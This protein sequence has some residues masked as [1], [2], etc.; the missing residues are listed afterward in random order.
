M[1]A[2]NGETGRLRLGI[3]PPA[4]VSPFA[5]VLR[6]FTRKFPLVTLSVCQND[7]QRLVQMLL[8]K[9]LDLVLGRSC[10]G[11]KLSGLRQR[12]LLIEEQGIVL[13]E[14]DPLA[15][16]GRIPIAKLEGTA[17]LLLHDNPHFGR[18]IMELA[19]R[20]GVKL[21]PRRVVDDFLSLY[22]AVRSGLGV[23]PCSLLLVD[24]LPHGLVGRPLRPAPPRLW[25]H[26][27]WLA[28]QPVPGV[29]RLLEMLV[30]EVV[31][32]SSDHHA[33]SVGL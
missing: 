7:Q 3:I 24:S 28:R 20:Q 13:R 14:D 19:A 10:S 21:Y 15:E 12:R 25:V 33:K 9:D 32:P 16:H 23:A 22:W 26:A 8:D 11:R 31:R 17:L 18:N 1:R 5:S 6:E 27:L 30:A 2:Q 29:G 4:A